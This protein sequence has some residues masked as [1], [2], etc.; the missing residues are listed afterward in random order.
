MGFA[1][2]LARFRRITANRTVTALYMLGLSVGH[3]AGYVA[4]YDVVGPGAA[5]FGFLPG[6]GAALIWG[7]RGGVIASIMAFPANAGLWQYLDETR[8]LVEA[9]GNPQFVLG[10]VMIFAIAVVVG[11]FRD[12]SEHL[13]KEIAHRRKVSDALEQSRERYALATAGTNDG[14][15]DWSV[16]QGTVFFSQRCEEMLGHG[17]GELGST[18]REWLDRLHP[19][20]S[21]AVKRQIAEAFQTEAEQVS[22][23]HRLLHRDGSYVWV[24]TRA[25]IVRDA[26]GT[27]V[28]LVGS[29]TDITERSIRDRLTNLPNRVLFLERLRYLAS[30]RATARE[31][32]SIAVAVLGIDNFSLINNSFGHAAGDKVLVEVALRL[33]GVVR[34]EDTVARLDSDRFS[35]AFAGLRD[36][37]ELRTLLNRVLQ[38]VS[39]PVSI[40]EESV[41]IRLTAGVAIAPTDELDGGSLLHDADVALKYAK[42]HARGDFV[43]YSDRIQETAVTTLRLAHDLRTALEE[44]QFELYF[45]PILSASTLR[46]VAAEAL[47]RWNHPT[48]G[49]LS[50]GEFISFAET[51]GLI[52]PIGEWV[53]DRAVDCLQS[54][55]HEGVS[56]FRLDINLSGAHFARTHDVVQRLAR[57]LEQSNVAAGR[58]GIEITETALLGSRTEAAEVLTAVRDLGVHIAVDDF[59]SGYSTLKY[60]QELPVDSVKID[61]SFVVGCASSMRNR[62]V[63]SSLVQLAKSLGLV[64]LAEGI[65]YED[66]LATVRDLDCQLVQGFLF[67]RPMREADFLTYVRSSRTDRVPPIWTGSR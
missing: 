40:G 9:M 7:V 26:T 13:Q 38:K 2:Q 67:S 25:L 31:E 50:P 66:Q 60:L 20:E 35:L 8:S 36:E 57:R 39:V 65:E 58:L 34:S 64:S 52:V 42:D 48:R 28:R 16:P 32:A 41:A 5:V 30:I 61:R 18:P 43:R 44:R 33:Q 24:L 23:E 19:D 49:V 45:Q 4:V 22:L 21:R 17:P 47:I 51:E 15:W 55:N 56:G 3:I 6:L 1:R 37:T 29:M 14:I 10:G 12:L 63:L 62:S 54:W 11:A 59:G 53:I 46:L 27:V